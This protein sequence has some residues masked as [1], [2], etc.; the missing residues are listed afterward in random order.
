M[1][2]TII[3]TL[4]VFVLTSC[5]TNPTYPIRPEPVDTVAQVD[6]ATVQPDSLTILTERVE[7]LEKDKSNSMVTRVFLSAVAAITV[8][9]VLLPALANGGN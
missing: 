6:S 2:A 7:Q 3:I 8:V 9:F 1:K 4:A 5:A